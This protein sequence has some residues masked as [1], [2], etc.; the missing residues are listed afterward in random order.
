MSDLSHERGAA[1]ARMRAEVIEGLSRP[2]KE[3]PSRYF[4]D[5][6]GSALF[7][8]ITRQPEYYL[9][10]AERALLE[11]AAP[12]LA[13]RL[14]S[15]T[16]VELG[17]GSAA[18][19]RILLD[20]LRAAGGA[21]AY[22]PV[23]VSGEFLAV[24]AHELRA[25]YPGLTVIPV[26]ADFTAELHLPNELPSPRLVAFLGSTLGNFDDTAAVALLS[27]VA[28][29]LKPHDHFLLG[30]DLRKDVAVL[31][32]A[33]DDAR[34]VTAEFNRNLLRV[35]NRQIGTDF[36]VDAFRHRAFYERKRHRIEMHLVAERPLTVHLPGAADVR[37]AAGE[38]VRTEISCKYSLESVARLLEAAGLRL[39]V[40]TPDAEGHYA[41]ALASSADG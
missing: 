6:R 25:D 33:Y 5:A 12:E 8:E 7:E 3:L 30:V 13:C 27:R 15:R 26:V 16:L 36:D 17:A 34:G 41:L 32:A 2:Q 20:A 38:S 24:T 10:R 14:R 1:P 29:E 22:V 21:D 28:A 9:T 11:R 37:F 18:K 40:W 35:V 19:T 31:E 23:D 39:D 4:Y